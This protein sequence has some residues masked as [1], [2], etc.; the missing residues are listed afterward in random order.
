VEKLTIKNS[1]DIG[2]AVRARRKQLGLTQQE[3]VEIAPFG[4]TFFSD[5]E[6]GKETAH[7]NKAIEAL[8]MLGLRLVIEVPDNS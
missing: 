7:L 6:N 4:A 2:A 1:K 3:L 5:L 8:R